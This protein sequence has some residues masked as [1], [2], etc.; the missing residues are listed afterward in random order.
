MPSCKI[1][2]GRIIIG[3]V[4]DLPRR[5]C[6]LL[7]VILHLLRILR[8]DVI[9]ECVVSENDSHAGQFQSLNSYSAAV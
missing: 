9:I 8:G 7:Q 1:Q 5:M 6:V 4:I 3:T 2:F